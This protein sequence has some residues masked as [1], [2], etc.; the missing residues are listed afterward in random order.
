MKFKILSI[1]LL[2]SIQVFPQILQDQLKQN[3]L[4]DAASVIN[5]TIGGN[6][7]ITGT[8]PALMTE[9][10]DGFITRMY[11]EATD[12]ILKSYSDPELIRKAKTELTNYSLRG[13]VLKRSDGKEIPV[14]LQKFRT[15]GN[16]KDNP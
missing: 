1:F 7:P 9:R 15:V 5:V 4:L 8:Y 6:F 10:V 13:I 12:L 11:G 2:I 3:Q 14:D 16:F